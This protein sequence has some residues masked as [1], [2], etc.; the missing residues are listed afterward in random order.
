MHSKNT[1]RQKWS[2]LAGLVIFLLVLA[3]CSGGQA[4]TTPPAEE[5]VEEAAQPTEEAIEAT[6]EE[7]AGEPAGAEEPA[8]PEEPTPAEEEA[9]AEEEAP[10][11]EE[12]APTP[13]ANTE[14]SLTM[15]VYDDGRIGVLTELGQQ[16]E[17]EYGIPVIVEAVDLGE[18]SN[19]ILLGAGTGTGPD[20][21]IIPH[22]NLGPLVENGAVAPVD[23]SDKANEY[24][25]NAIDGFTY[26]GELYGLPLAVEN[27]GFFRNTEMVPEA[28]TTWD[29]VF[30]IG[31]E[32]VDSG[33]AEIAAA[34]PDLTYNIY[35]V[36][37]SYGGYIFGRDAEGNFTPDDIGMNSEGFIEGMTWVQT[38]IEN[39]LASENV[40]WEAAHVLF[41]TGRAPFI[42]TGPWAINR[43]KTAG[44][45]YAISA[46][47]AAEEG[48]EP[49]YPFLGVQGIVFNANSSDLLLAQTFAMETIATQEGMQAIFDAEPR[50][51]AW[52]SIFE[53]ANDPDTIGFNEAGINA[54]PMPSIPAMGF[55][56]DAWVNAGTLVAT[57]EMSPADAL[58]N[59]VDQIQAQIAESQ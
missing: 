25:P 9:A 21:A 22:D 55:V 3:A 38:M 19:Q 59:A 6:E 30:T 34:F 2:L 50:P 8:P 39:G 27:I 45:P 48:G 46:F 29:E 52:Q 20:M 4:G 57:G 36:Y 56:W 42:F 51:S 40:D 28:P 24:L 54:D 23:L 32:L 49:G 7:G 14:N 16:F 11:E 5:S 53:A 31:Q 44:V 12:M 10:A 35:P 26:N 1:K 18:I 37:T 33:E 43:F 41:E 58:Q 47:P 17:A 13:V 15:W